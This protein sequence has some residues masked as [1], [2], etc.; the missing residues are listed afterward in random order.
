LDQFCAETR[1]RP[2]SFK[3]ERQ[4]SAAAIASRPRRRQEV[5]LPKPKI[6]LGSGLAFPAAHKAAVFRNLIEPYQQWLRTLEL[7][8]IRNRLGQHFLHS[9]LS[10]LALA[11][12]FHAERE[13]GVLQKEQ[14]SFPGPIAALSQEFN[15]L[16]YFGTHRVKCSLWGEPLMLLFYCAFFRV[17]GHVALGWSLSM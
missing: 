14:G 3:W 8:Q 17:D 1:R 16:F 2:G 11:A 10:V 9:L 5:L 7:G 6:F 13:N 15:G 4:V 12:D